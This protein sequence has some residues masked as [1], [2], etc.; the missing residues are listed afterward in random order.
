MVCMTKSE[1]ERN[2]IMSKL[3][4]VEVVFFDSNEIMNPEDYIPPRY[5]SDY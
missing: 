4:G 3:D 1:S 2:L 5:L